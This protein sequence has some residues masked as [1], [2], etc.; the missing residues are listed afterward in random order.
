[1][2]QIIR[3]ENSV[4]NSNSNRFV[5]ALVKECFQQN[6]GY[7][8][9]T[10]HKEEELYKFD[11]SQP[12]IFIQPFEFEIPS[13]WNMDINTTAKVI[14][15]I[16]ST[17]VLEEEEPT[18]LLIGRG[19]TVNKPLQEML[20]NTYANLIITNSH[21][22]KAQL[23]DFLNISDVIV[24][25]TNKE[26]KIPG[27]YYAKVVFD[28]GNTINNIDAHFTYSTIYN[29]K[30]IGKLTVQQIIQNVKEFEDKNN[31]ER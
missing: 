26:V 30:S 4:N 6:V 9:I 31:D 25:A 18:I 3:S 17:K 19:E 23:Y 29:R 12:T 14:F 27:V 1:M 20:K 28:A 21:T 2:F 15:D 10:I 22:S 24:C 13:H 7:K 8:I 16:I 5:N 11:E